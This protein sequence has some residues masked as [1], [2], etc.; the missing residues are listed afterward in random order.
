MQKNAEVLEY[1]FKI[2]PRRMW[3]SDGIEGLDELF[4]FLSLTDN[5][6][7][8]KDAYDN[9]IKD[10]EDNNC[11]VCVMPVL[12]KDDLK[13]GA[14]VVIMNKKDVTTGVV[15][16]ESVHVADYICEQ[17]GIYSQGFRDGNEA[18]AYLVGYVA[19][20]ISDSIKEFKKKKI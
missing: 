6:T 4:T 14:L 15:A 12:R 19:D 5:V 20:C 7:E 13:Y 18:Y 16:H 1:V 11:T 9:L 3:V 2:Y 8:A 17:L 10:K